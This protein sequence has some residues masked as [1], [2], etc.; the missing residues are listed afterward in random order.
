MLKQKPGQEAG[1]FRQTVNILLR[2]TLFKQTT[3]P[4]LQI[5]PILAVAV[6]EGIYTTEKA[7]PTHPREPMRA[8]VVTKL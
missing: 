7:P 6:R 1:Q 2:P 5:R 4:V 3:W 8:T